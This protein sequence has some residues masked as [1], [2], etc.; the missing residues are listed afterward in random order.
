MILVRPGNYQEDLLIDGKSLILQADPVAEGE[1][2][3]RN[4]LVRNLSPS[5]GARFA[6]SCS[7][8]AA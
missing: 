7:R 3:I 4:L 5:Q 6:A 2:R 1:V 8:A